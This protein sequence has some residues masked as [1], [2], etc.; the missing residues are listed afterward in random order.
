VFA[1]LFESPDEAINAM[2]SPSP[3]DG[4]KGPGCT[5]SLEITNQQ[6][7]VAYIDC[8]GSHA[9]VA[10]KFGLGHGAVRWRLLEVGLPGLGRAASSSMRNA[11]EAV[12]VEGVS[13]EKA[14]K[15]HGVDRA[16]LERMLIQS[17]GAFRAALIG[18]RRSE[19]GVTMQHRPKPMPPP[20]QQR[21]PNPG[22]LTPA[23]G[24]T[25]D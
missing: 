23:A 5:A 1:A 21:L 4:A 22:P 17:A 9:A 14:S 20:R 16:D 25:V 18:M 24:V 15:E 12:L 7:L 6:L 8:N 3:H 2:L 13:I 10:R 11:A 19:R